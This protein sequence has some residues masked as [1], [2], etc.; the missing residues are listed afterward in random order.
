MVHDPDEVSAIRATSRRTV[1]GGL[2]AGLGIVLIGPAER[3]TAA[4][5]G[6]AV[7][8]PLGGLTTIATS[9]RSV[10]QV[11]TLLGATLTIT[12][13]PVP[14]GSTVAVA[15]DER[16]YRSAPPVLTTASGRVVPCRLSRTTRDSTSASRTATI[17]VGEALVPG[18]TYTLSLGARRLVRYPEDVVDAPGPVQVTVT[19]KTSGGASRKRFDAPEAEHPVW[20]LKV[21]AGWQPVYWGDSFHSWTPE[22]VTVASTGPADVPA[23]TVVSATL[24]ARLFARAQFEPLEG[25]ASSGTDAART[26]DVLRALWVLTEPLTAGTRT[27]LRLVAEVAD[28]VVALPGLHQPTV[29]ARAADAAVGQR[30]TGWESASREDSAYDPSTRLT[31]GLDLLT[32]LRPR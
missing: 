14:S 32:P 21:G 12:S 6:V 28:L 8:A 22:L 2:A 17:T 18:E 23:G 15:F 11:P 16:L 20:G 27:S 4:G 1:L 31:Y 29:T 19:D 24:D 13:R 26:D 10:V 3:A 30:L 5:A 7:T 25:R 9:T